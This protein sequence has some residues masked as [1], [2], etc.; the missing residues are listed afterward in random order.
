MAGAIR[1]WL[2]ELGLEQY[3]ET[4]QEIDLDLDLA[5]DL[6]DVGHPGLFLPLH[7]HLLCDDRQSPVS[8]HAG[9]GRAEVRADA[10]RP[11]ADRR[12]AG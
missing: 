8:R 12:Q 2:R 9:R 6:G 3:A 1:H 11:S 10:R 7:R 4:F 5:A